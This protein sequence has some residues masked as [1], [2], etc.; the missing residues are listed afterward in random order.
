MEIHNKNIFCDWLTV[1]QTHA[2]PHE[3]VNDGF[4]TATL[5]DGQVEYRSPRPL[6]LRGR[7]GSNLQISSDGQTVRFSGNI[8]RWNRSENLFGLNLDDAKEEINKLLLTHNLPPFSGGSI[9]QLQD[10][11][12][13][14]TGAKISRCDMTANLATGS[15]YNREKF[16]AFIQSQNHPTLSKSLYD[17]ATYYGQS[18]DARTILLYDKAKDL[19]DKALK[20]ALKANDS[21]QVEYLTKL[22]HQANS[23]GIVRYEVAFKKSLK[24]YNCRRWDN[25]NHDS[26]CELF[27]KDFCT[28]TTETKALDIEDIPVPA[29]GTLMMYLAGLPVRK[30]IHRNTFSKHKKILLEYGYDISNTNVSAIQPKQKTIVLRVAEIPDFYEHAQKQKLEAVNQ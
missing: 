1:S 23:D 5:A 12:N 28:M 10:G 2:E 8:S 13:L 4:T 19:S 11:P 21:S 9:L 25:A 22:I 24:Y 18:S 20:A 30:L 16:L 3:P 17:Q 15:A 26:L 7:H 6:N 14:Y 27:K 29:L